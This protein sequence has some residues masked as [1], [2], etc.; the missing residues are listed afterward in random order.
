VGFA[1]AA[2]KQGYSLEQIAEV[3]TRRGEGQYAKELLASG[4]DSPRN[5]GLAAGDGA[6]W[7]LLAP[8][9]A[10]GGAAVQKLS[11]DDR[12][13]VSIFKQLRDDANLRERNYSDQNYG[14][15]LA[16]RVVGAAASGKLNPMALKIPGVGN[17]TWGGR[18]LNTGANAAGGAGAASLL[19]T[20]ENLRT[21]QGAKNAG[22]DAATSAV[23]GGAAGLVL[24][25]AVEGLGTLAKG[26]YRMLPE[27]AR[28]SLAAVPGAARRAMPPSASSTLEL[29]G[30]LPSGVQAG[31]PAMQGGA[32]RVMNRLQAQ[33]MTIDEL[34]RLAQQADGP[35]I[36]AELIG[37]KGVRELGTANILGNKAPE[38]I[39]GMLDERAAGEPDRWLA[40]LERLLPTPTLDRGTFRANAMQSAAE[41]AAPGYGASQGTG[42]P[43]EELGGIVRRLQQL[44]NDGLD[45]WKLAK[46]SDEAMP[47]MPEDELTSMTVGQLQRL[48]QVL[49]E[50]IQYGQADAPLGSIERVA[51]ARLQSIRAD[52]DR[53]AKARGG[54]PFQD[55]DRAI[56]TGE[57]ASESFEAGYRAAQMARNEEEVTRLAKA[58]RDPEAFRQGI[59]AY[60]QEQVIGA[61]DGGAGGFTN[62]YAPAMATARA[63]AITRAGLQDAT[64]MPEL[65]RL[66]I[67]GANRAR[68]RNTTLGNS[69]TAQRGADVAEAVGG[70][71][72]PLELGAAALNPMGAGQRGLSQLWNGARRRVLGDEMDDM[73]PLLMGGGPGQPSR[74][75]VIAELRR[76]GPVLQAKWA[77]DVLLR[78]R[79]AAA[80]GERV[81]RR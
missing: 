78:G 15:A 62:P 55:A 36:I 3:L 57:G 65:E 38:K 50:K 7:G 8:M 81:T 49:D 20:E 59:G 47:P 18:A 33:G 76:M 26:M 19:N 56:A 9:A 64:A 71:V 72:N 48:R 41:T 37:E 61:R 24:S 22:R 23:I 54:T 67:S 4:Q 53:L 29:Q 46:L 45:I 16:A 63:R 77:Q 79:G 74:E 60:R 21:M 42:V 68:T 70:A 73:A 39:R 31:T 80:V 1:K 10:A 25:P 27:T 51:N 30:G 11:G 14:K 66:A 32:A 75:D 69:A 34:E 44:R 13:L 12:D 43:A 35:D 6:A 40:A 17:A 5:F 2:R 52:I 58:A 28:G